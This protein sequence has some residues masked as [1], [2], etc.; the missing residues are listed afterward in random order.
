MQPFGDLLVPFLIAAAQVSARRE[1]VAGAGEDQRPQILVGIDEMHRLLDAEI[2]RWR[3]RVACMRA[4]DGAPQDRPFAFEPHYQFIA[5]RME[6]SAY[7][8]GS[9]PEALQIPS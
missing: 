8:D 4:I 7:M 6:E 9:L 3:Q 2:H 5:E 1:N